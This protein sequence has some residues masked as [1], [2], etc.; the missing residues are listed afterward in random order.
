MT[1]R[2]KAA[3][4][5]WNVP[6][7]KNASL[8][9][10]PLPERDDSDL[11]QWRWEFLRR[12]EEYRQD[13]LRIRSI[14]RQGKLALLADPPILDFTQITPILVKEQV[15]DPL[16]FQRKYKLKK[17]L[18][19]AH[20]KPRHLAFYF[21]PLNSITLTFDLDM[22]ISKEIVRAERILK[23]YQKQLKGVIQRATYPDKK[24]WPLFLRAIDAYAQ[25]LSLSEIGYQLLGLDKGRHDRNQATT[26]AKSFLEIGRRF[27]KKLPIPPNKS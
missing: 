18:N 23:R 12:D 2:S 20:I 1:R 17:L 13:W 7:W 26:N 22:P 10:V 19:P 11:R 14:D 16:Y 15:K 5:L 4:N 25:E 24:K 8:Y 3:T 6:D 21:T 27:W 9:P